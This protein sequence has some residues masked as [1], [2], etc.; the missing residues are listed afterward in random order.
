MPGY[1]DACGSGEILGWVTDPDPNETLPAVICRA[2]DGRSME[3]RAIH[4]RVDVCQVIGRQGTFG[5]AIP[6]EQI[7]HLGPKLRLYNSAGTMLGNGEVDLADLPD[8]SSVPHDNEKVHIF[9]HVQKSAGT[10]VRVALEALYRKCEIALIYPDVPG[11]SLTNFGR[12]PRYQ[13]QEIKF[14]AGHTYFGV[15]EYLEKPSRYV[16]V[17]RNPID[18][19]I[20]NFWHHKNSD[21]NLII[22][23]GKI[24]IEQVVNEGLTEEFDNYAT[25]VICGL[26][27]DAVPIGSVTFEAVRAAIHNIDTMFDCLAILEK[28]P[29][30]FD[31]LCKSLGKVPPV[32]PRLNVRSRSHDEPSDKIDWKKVMDNNRFNQQ[33]YDHFY[34]N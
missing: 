24:P 32:L 27:A 6:I 25:R 29:A 8:T 4:Y 21:Y 19:L 12:L 17:L 30:D 33:L 22:D 1:V 11:I 5:F 18:R 20:S 2:H 16:T 9:L 15:H 3:F 14:L 26:T 28:F 23:G 13:R 34:K 7:R 31:R 10:S